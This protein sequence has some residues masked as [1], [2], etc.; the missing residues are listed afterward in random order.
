MGK[1]DGQSDICPVRQIRV[2]LA[3]AGVG[4]RGSVNNGVST[5]FF[6]NFSH[7]IFSGISQGRGGYN[8]VPVHAEEAAAYKAVW[9]G[10]KNFHK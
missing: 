6:N 8:I 3:S 4:D 7:I 2:V 10:Q 5:A 9:S 1:H